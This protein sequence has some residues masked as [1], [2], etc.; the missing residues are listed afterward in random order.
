[1]TTPVRYPEHRLS[2]AG[3]KR[4]LAMTTTIAYRMVAV[5]HNLVLSAE[6][7]NETP[8]HRRWCAGQASVISAYL[9]QRFPR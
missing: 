6:D 2:K 5:L 1:M 3:A 7:P 8:S 4:A 9:N